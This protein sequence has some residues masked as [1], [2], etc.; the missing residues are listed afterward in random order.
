[1]SRLS[2]PTS[3]SLV[4]LIQSGGIMNNVV[5]VQDVR[6]A[7]AIY[8][9]SLQFLRGKSKKQAPTAARVSLAPRVTQVQQSL[10]VD[11]MFI[12]KLP[13]LVGVLVPLN[14]TMCAHLKNRGVECVAVGIRSFIN[15]AKSRNF[16]IVVLR[17]DGE[18]RY[19][20]S[21]PSCA[22]MTAAYPS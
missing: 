8:G 14:L 6:Y 2:F 1:M 5:I 17:A 15:N 19:K 11:I 18:A 13:F 21:C 16:D 3:Q 10:A 20:Q 12:K 9:M 22:L 4:E 7:D